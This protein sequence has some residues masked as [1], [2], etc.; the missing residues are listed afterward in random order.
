MMAGYGFTF[1]VQNKLGS[2]L[3]KRGIPSRPDALADTGYDDDGNAV[4][5]RYTGLQRWAGRWLGCSYCVGATS[6]V[7]VF[8]LLLAAGVLGGPGAW[9]WC[10]LL[11]LAVCAFSYMADEATKLAERS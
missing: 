3:R 9:A 6:G 2:V 8:L 1:G 11:A 4:E 7:V 5:R 10:A